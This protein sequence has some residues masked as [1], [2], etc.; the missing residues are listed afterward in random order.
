M[1]KTEKRRGRP[2]MAGS[3]RKRNM[4]TMRMR[5]A[6]KADLEKEAAANQRSLSE[7]IEHQL[8][9]QALL[10]SLLPTFGRSDLFWQMAMF[11]HAITSMEKLAG[12]AWDEDDDT[13]EKVLVFARDL[14]VEAKRNKTLSAADR[15]SARN[16]MTS[17][18]AAP[19]GND[20]NQDLSPRELQ[21]LEQLAQGK[22]NKII[23][24]ELDMSES[25]VKVYVNRI[26]KKMN[27]RRT[28]VVLMSRDADFLGAKQ[29][30][31]E[32]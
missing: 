1:E 16:R 7:E 18:A 29:R 11:G 5:D 24:H 13:A 23:A 31:G 12:K 8:E 4:V 17:E 6:L 27:A 26:M 15:L 25:T 28:K 14:I 20:K 30:V 9:Q 32:K 3:N 19:V 10:R 22:Q 21:V 2:R